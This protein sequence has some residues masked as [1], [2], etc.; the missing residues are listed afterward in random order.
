MRECAMHKEWQELV[1]S[2][3]VIRC[4]HLGDEYM[5]EVRGRRVV[6]MVA[7]VRG[8][9]GLDGHE[10]VRVTSDADAA[11]I[12]AEMTRRMLAGAPFGM[13]Y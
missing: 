13:P 3:R 5:N 7:R 2:F 1:P 11:H 8:E 6:H 12:W 4:A 9:T 10:Y